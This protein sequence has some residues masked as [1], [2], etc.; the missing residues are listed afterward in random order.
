[1][2]AQH[3][4]KRIESTV[5]DIITD[6]CSLSTGDIQAL[7][8]LSDAIVRRDNVKWVNHLDNERIETGT[9]RVFTDE[10][11]GLR[12]VSGDIRDAFVWITDSKGTVEHLVPVRWFIKMHNEGGVVYGNF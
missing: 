11:Y 5:E 7:G 10:S 2:T 8:H 3:Y 12:L 9:L 4:A 1:M 6:Y